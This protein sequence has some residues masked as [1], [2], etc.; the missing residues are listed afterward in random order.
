MNR[1]AL[2]LAQEGCLLTL[3]HAVFLFGCATWCDGVSD[4]CMMVVVAVIK[5]GNHTPH[6]LILFPPLSSNKLTNF[7]NR[8]KQNKM[9]RRS[10][11]R[12]AAVGTTASSTVAPSAS[13]TE[14][15]MEAMTYHDRSAFSYKGSDKGEEVGARNEAAFMNYEEITPKTLQ[16]KLAV[17]H[18]VNLLSITP[19]YVGLFFI[20]SW[21]WGIFLWDL[22]ARKH[23]ETVV[24]ERP[25]Q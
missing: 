22:Y 17:P 5:R 13:K 25:K 8:I 19:I 24:I 2:C 4:T 15:K 18:H 11:S 10:I 16:H 12:F 14:F 9:M 7:R 6:K 21:A 3:Q 20:A 23:Y 1:H